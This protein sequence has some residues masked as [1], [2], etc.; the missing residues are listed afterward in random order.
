MFMV[1]CYGDQ[2]V[3]R[4]AIQAVGTACGGFFLVRLSFTCLAPPDL[5]Y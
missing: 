4:P 1:G 2:S 5:S 3:S